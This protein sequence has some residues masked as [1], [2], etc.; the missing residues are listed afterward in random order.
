MF[1]GLEMAGRT[2][3]SY[4]E[5]LINV[6]MV[7]LLKSTGIACKMCCVWTQYPQCTSTFSMYLYIHGR[8]AR[9]YRRCRMEN[10]EK[11]VPFLYAGCCWQDCRNVQVERISS[12]NF[13]LNVM[14]TNSLLN[15]VVNYFMKKH[16]RT[17]ISSYCVPCY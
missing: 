4:W 2:G 11:G 5:W 1:V 15:F 3:Y 16:L 8:I 17:N 9:L 12:L 6:C 10:R 13:D 7:K 14:R